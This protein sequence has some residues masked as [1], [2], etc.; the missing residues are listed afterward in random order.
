[1][2]YCSSAELMQFIDQRDIADMV[3]DNNVRPTYD[4]LLVDPNVSLALAA[5][6][7]QI[8]SYAQIGQR[9]T[10]AQLLALTGDDAAILKM[11]CAW[12]A[13]GI[14]VTRRSRDA[15]QYPAWRD[16][17]E[18]LMQLRQG[19]TLFNV[20]GN[21][22]SQLPNQAFPTAVQFAQVN[23]IRTAVPSYY[24]I[25]RKQSVVS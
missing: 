12:L 3:T 24:P 13:F 14:L 16:A 1:M 21:I 4:M 2:A 22:G 11:M 15:E 20:L 18:M 9:Y 17:K 8:T 7:G 19:V 5:A 10:P 25:R 23:T 6:T